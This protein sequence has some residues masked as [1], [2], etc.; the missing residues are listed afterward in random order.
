MSVPSFGQQMQ[1]VLTGFISRLSA[2]IYNL[3]TLRSMQGSHFHLPVYRIDTAD[4]IRL[5]RLRLPI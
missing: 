4:F 2:D 5:A 1:L 3:K